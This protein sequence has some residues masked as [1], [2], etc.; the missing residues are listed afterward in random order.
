[1]KLTGYVDLIYYLLEVLLLR[2]GNHKR[3]F[4][5]LRICITNRIL[6]NFTNKNLQ[7]D[8]YFGHKYVILLIKIDHE[9][10]N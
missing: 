6:A 5:F 1:M 4:L 10:Q 8:E 2:L 7:M 9:K 3:L